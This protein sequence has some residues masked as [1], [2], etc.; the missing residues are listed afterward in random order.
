[1]RKR[2]A[3]GSRRVAAA[4]RL[5]SSR[6]RLPFA[7]GGGLAVARAEAVGSSEAPGESWAAPV[8]PGAHRGAKIYGREQS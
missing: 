4:A 2:L 3:R 1:M 6:A 7:R 5:R 8:R